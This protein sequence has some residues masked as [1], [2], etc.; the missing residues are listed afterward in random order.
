MPPEP[1][2][3][4]GLSPSEYHHVVGPALKIAA[5]VAATRGDPMLLNDM[6]SMLALLHITSVLGKCELSAPSGAPDASARE[7]IA[8]APRGACVMVLR[9]GQLEREAINDCLQ[10]LEQAHAMLEADGVF[11]DYD[12]P[13]SRAW[14]HLNDGQNHTAEHVLKRTATNL[15]AAIDRWE[16]ARATH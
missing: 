11:N 16:A 2:D 8:N 7:V 5:E 13:I 10:A 9:E 3:I 6:A 12:E 1:D 4:A 14:H 15:V